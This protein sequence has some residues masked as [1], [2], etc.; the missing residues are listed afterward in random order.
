MFFT[1]VAYIQSLSKI[2]HTLKQAL[3][4]SYVQFR[5][6]LVTLGASVAVK[7]DLR[8]FSV[9]HAAMPAGQAESPSAASKTKAAHAN[10]PC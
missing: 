5:A 10:S 4:T 6:G 1:T 8:L 7:C 2:G 3:P 9:Q